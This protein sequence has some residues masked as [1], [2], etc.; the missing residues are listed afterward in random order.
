MGAFS[1]PLG[2]VKFFVRGEVPKDL[3]ETY[4]R[5]IRLRAF[6]P[7]VPEEDAVERVGWCVAGSPLDLALGHESVYF[8]EYIVLGFRR[9]KW[10]I[11]GA[12]LKAHFQEQARA[13]LASKKKEQLSRTEKADLRMKVTTELK[14]RLLPSLGSWDLVWNPDR[15]EAWFWGRSRAVQE[16]LAAHFESTFGLELVPT[17]PYTVALSRELDESAAGR[18]NSLKPTPLHAERAERAPEAE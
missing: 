16:H 13:L 9:D 15:G 1:G 11:P 17:S 6:R 3:R 2:A 4:I 10:T 5:R 8:N 18:L 7:L 14:H 12:L